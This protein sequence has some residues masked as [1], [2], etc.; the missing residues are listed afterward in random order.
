[1][2]E[3]ELDLFEFATRNVTEAGARAAKVVGGAFSKPACSANVFTT[4]QITFSVNP[5][6][7]TIPHL[8]I[9]LNTR[10]AAISAAR[11]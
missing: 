1:V 4:F 9:D 11:R 7:Q 5:V 10:P 8:L 3:K 2:P 6:P